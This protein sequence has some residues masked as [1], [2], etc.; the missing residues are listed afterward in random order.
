M[1]FHEIRSFETLDSTNEYLKRIADDAM[2]G[3]VVCAKEQTAG[4]GRIG[5]SW[6]SQ[7][8]EGAWFSVMV[9][10]ERLN[11]ENAA[12][13]VFVCAF[14][15][16]SSLRMLTGKDIQ[17][18]WPNDIVINGRKLVGILCESSLKAGNVLWSVCG[19][20]I[21]LNTEQFPEA[22]PWA[23]SLYRETGSRYDAKTVTEHFLIE[24]DIAIERMLTDG[25]KAIL[26]AIKP[27]SATVGQI[28]H[29]EQGDITIIGRAVDF[30]KDGSLLIETENGIRQVNVGD[31]SVRGLMGYV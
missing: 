15:T 25:M 8:D 22:L 7:K 27:L 23:T 18:K 17:I 3:L 2:D 16:A 13:L 24:F 6:T 1:R 11:A 28:V 4:K 14:A 21:N 31:V 9:K 12:G 29:A 10:D 5:R 19:I 20:G 26:D 30:A